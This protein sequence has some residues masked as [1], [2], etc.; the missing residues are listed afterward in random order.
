MYSKGGFFWIFSLL[1]TI[2]NSF[3][4]R[5][6]DSTVSRILG[7]NPGRFA[8]TALAV[9]R[10]NHI[11]STLMYCNVKIASVFKAASTWRW[12]RFP[13][14]LSCRRRISRPHTDS[15]YL[16]NRP[17]TLSS[18]AGHAQRICY[19]KKKEILNVVFCFAILGAFWGYAKPHGVARV[20]TPGQNYHLS[21]QTCL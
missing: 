16:T 13:L 21:S 20:F 19:W 15:R 8:T 6:S 7:S 1:C 10:S 17:R 4:C 12:H 9:R 11:P 18:P 3:I 2:F 5:P 14:H